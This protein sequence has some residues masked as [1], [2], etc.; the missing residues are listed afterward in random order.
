MPKTAT[1]RAGRAGAGRWTRSSATR[2][3]LAQRARIVVAAAKG[4]SNTQVAEQGGCLISDG[5]GL[6][7]A[8]RKPITGVEKVVAFLARAV[9]VPD[10]VATTAWLN[11]MPGARIDIGS[12]AT[13]VSLVVKDGRITRIT[14]SP[15]RASWDGWKGGGTAAVT[16]LRFVAWQL[17]P[18]RDER[19]S[20]NIGRE[21][22]PY[23]SRALVRDDTQIPDTGDRIGLSTAAEF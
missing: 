22:V 11:G 17:I 10:F 12:R 15:T 9:R 5:G 21:D 23:P 1:T 18:G 2:A 16:V 8:A 14:R 4:W 3:G 20:R 7:A 6:V 13:A 19:P